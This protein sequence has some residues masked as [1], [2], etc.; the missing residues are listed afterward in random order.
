MS[1]VSLDITSGTTKS[2]SSRSRKRR[3]DSLNSPSLGSY[4]DNATKTKE[5]KFA[6]FLLAAC[7]VG[8]ILLA[9]YSS[10]EPDYS[11]IPLMTKVED[12]ISRAQCDKIIQEAEKYGNWSIADDEIDGK[13]SYRISLYTDEA[14][15]KQRE[16]QAFKKHKKKGALDEYGY[17]TDVVMTE[18]DS[19]LSYYAEQFRENFNIPH[20]TSHKLSLSLS[21]SLY[22]YL[23]I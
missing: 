12:F 8:L 6:A 10:F 5:G 2:R 15:R 11:R 4:V 22:L 1:S 13:P 19:M 14:L 23:Y 7:C 18:Q 21:L 20:R 17:I 16:F 9:Y 3:D